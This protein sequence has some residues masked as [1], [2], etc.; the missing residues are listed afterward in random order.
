MKN[1]GYEIISMTEAGIDA[2]I[3][4]DGETFAQN[5]LIKAGTV[6]KLCGGPAMADDSGLMIDQLG[7]APGVYSARYLGETTPYG[8][9][10]KKILEMLSGV[11]FKKRAAR[12][13]CVIAF[14][15]ARGNVLTAE[16]VMEGYIAY[17]AAG[18]NGF[19]YDPIFY[20]PDYD[21]TSAQ[22]GADEKNKISHRGVALR[23]MCEKLSTEFILS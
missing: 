7:G 11:P 2:E 3:A 1:S 4:E 18:E 17:E 19:G 20:L 21:K 9:K 23:L 10:N 22:L 16:G 13:V 5:A 6:A 15:D 12:F 8:E 14:D